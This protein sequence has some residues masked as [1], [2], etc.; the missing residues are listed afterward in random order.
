LI[1]VTKCRTLGCIMRFKTYTAGFEL[2][3]YYRIGKSGVSVN[4]YTTQPII[5]TKGT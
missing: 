1:K 5:V 4:R 3:F 2:W